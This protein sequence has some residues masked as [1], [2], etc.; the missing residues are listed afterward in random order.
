VKVKD[1]ILLDDGNIELRV[2]AVEGTEI[3]C[4]VISGGMLSDHKGMNLPGVSVSAP[5]L[6]ETDRKDAR[7]ALGM[8]VDFLALSFVRQAEEILQLREIVRESGHSVAIVAKIEK[9]EALEHIDEILAASDAVMVARGDLGVEL[10]PQAVPTVQYQLIDRARVHRKPV[11]VAT[12]MLESMIE[13]PRPT[14]AEVTD[15]ATAVRGGADAVMLSGETAAGRHPVAAVRIMDEIARQTEG[16]LWEQGAFGTLTKVHKADPPLSVEDALSES[17][18]HLS[19]NLLVRAIVVISLQG[20]SLS[21]MSAAR[22]AAP[23]IGICP[24]MHACRVA[25]L[26]WGVFPITAKPG[27]IEEP[28][29]FAREAVRNFRL[30]EKEATILIVRGFSKDPDQNTPSVTIAQV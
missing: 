2:R 24:D 15:V 12:Q 23:I 3:Q 4:D 26:L 7:F 16:Y 14:R 18:A 6:T 29:S 9:P 28:L 25:N 17:M 8:G 11:I 21:V 5:A 10:P 1:R 13:H 20:R 19:R 30:A 22:P 27:Q